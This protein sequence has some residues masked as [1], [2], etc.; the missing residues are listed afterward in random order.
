MP[1]LSRRGFLKGL[2]ATA[3]VAAVPAVVAPEVDL[4]YEHWARGEGRIWSVPGRRAP[5]G[6]YMTTE[7]EYV[8]R[9][10]IRTELTVINGD[11]SAR[12][13]GF[14]VHENIGIGAYNPQTVISELLQTTK[15]RAR[16]AE[17]MTQPLRT[18]RDYV[19]WGRRTFSIDP[20]G[21][22]PLNFRSTAE[23]R[24]AQEAWKT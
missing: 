24:A 18:R 9:I 4:D 1:N 16:L 13:I 7:P 21:D 5:T 3:A 23:A 20:V 22:G 15:G 2:F 10:P 8:G 11:P 6:L 17:S 12:T 19:S 14:S